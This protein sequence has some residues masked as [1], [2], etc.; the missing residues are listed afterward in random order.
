VFLARFAAALGQDLRDEWGRP[1]R[2]RQ[3]SEGVELRSSGPNG[4][5]GDRD[6]IVEVFGAHTYDRSTF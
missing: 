3:T 2:V 1:L 4:V 6:D 5:F